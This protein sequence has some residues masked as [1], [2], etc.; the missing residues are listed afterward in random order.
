MNVVRVF[1]DGIG[2]CSVYRRS[3]IVA[4]AIYNLE[5]FPGIVSFLRCVNVILDYADSRAACAV[6][7][8][9]ASELSFP[10]RVSVSTI[11]ITRDYAAG[12]TSGTVSSAAAGAIY[13]TAALTKRTTVSAFSAITVAAA[14]A[15]AILT[16]AAVCSVAAA[17][18]A[19]TTTVAVAAVAAVAAAT[20][21]ARVATTTAAAAASAAAFEYFCSVQRIRST[22]SVS[23]SEISATTA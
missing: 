3:V 7:R 14:T 19:A 21:A 1:A 9:S 20:A 18:A 13:I 12:R 16:V 23:R 10:S 11:C 15:A 8:A 2:E 6:S 22:T 17:T 5:Y 4:N